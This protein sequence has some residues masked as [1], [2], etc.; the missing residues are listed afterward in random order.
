MNEIHRRELL[1]KLTSHLLVQRGFE[2]PKD[3]DIE[4]DAKVEDSQYSLCYED[5]E[6]IL[7]GIDKYGM[8]LRPKGQPQNPTVTYT[9]SSVTSPA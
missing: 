8:E 5:V 6:A 4:W 9:S 2:K 1:H 3:Y 7:S